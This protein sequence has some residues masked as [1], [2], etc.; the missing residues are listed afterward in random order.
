MDI[1]TA[2]DD[3]AR[4]LQVELVD[5]QEIEGEKLEN[6]KKLV[7]VD[8]PFESLFFNDSYLIIANE[9]EYQELISIE[10]IKSLTESL[11]IKMP[12]FNIFIWA[13]SFQKNKAMKTFIQED[14]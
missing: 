13:G 12:A 1:F 14:N 10:P 2:L 8:L 3:F 7:G 11:L 6:F 4:L 5:L 9:S